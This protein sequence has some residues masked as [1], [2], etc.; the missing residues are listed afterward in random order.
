M[1]KHAYH[2]MVLGLLFPCTTVYDSFGGSRSNA[3]GSTT[4]SEM[5]ADTLATL[6]G[7]IRNGLTETDLRNDAANPAEWLLMLLDEPSLWYLSDVQFIVGDAQKKFHA[8]RLILSGRSPVFKNM[9]GYGRNGLPRP[10]EVGCIVHGAIWLLCTGSV[11][12]VSCLSVSNLQRKFASADSDGI[13]TESSVPV[14]TS[15]SR[16]WDQTP[17]FKCMVRKY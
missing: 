14:L 10:D 6:Y 2:V 1:A 3:V 13:W 8:H 9:F 7:F 4:F 5:H 15:D 16:F 11:L 17:E 12:V